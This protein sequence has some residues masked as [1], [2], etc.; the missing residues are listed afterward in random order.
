MTEATP[1]TE[2]DLDAL[3][4]G[5]SSWAI[6]WRCKASMRDSLPTLVWSS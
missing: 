4:K 5:D 1:E 3:P 6:A 2:L